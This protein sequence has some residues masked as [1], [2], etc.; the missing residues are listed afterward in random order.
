MWER[1]RSFVYDR[2]IVSLTATWYFEVLQVLPENCHI[3]DV[4]I[5]TGAAL[6]ANARTLRAKN[7]TVVGVDYDRAY[8]TS[9]EKAIVEADLS[10]HVSVVHASIYE[11]TPKDNRLFDHIYFSGSFMILP[12]PAEALRKVV[13]LLLDR[14]DGRIYFTQ[15]FEL[16]KNPFLEWFK[17]KLLSITSI[18]FGNVSYEGD[19]DEALHA[20]RVQVEHMEVIDDGH[21]VEGKREARLIVARSKLYVQETPEYVT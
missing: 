8:V 17:P 2:A 6:I 7:I 4:G 13:D 16:S 11:F 1:A 18:D 21:R 14:E 20:A 9:C 10:K 3:L 12:Q 15:T 5:G 19:F